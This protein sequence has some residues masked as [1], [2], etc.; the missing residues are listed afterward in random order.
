MKSDYLIWSGQKDCAQFN[1][2]CHIEAYYTTDN[3]R[4]WEIVETYVRNCNWARDKELLADP[5]Q[6]ICE[7]YK[8]KEGNQMFF[9]MDNPLQ[10]IG[11]SDFYKQKRL[12]FEHVVG[13][14]K[15]SEYLIVAEVCIFTDFFVNVA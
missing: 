14:A 15:F 13:F 6:I 3:G 4:K 11:G 10:L 12:L 9:G 5:N 8:N 7:S 1:P 2:N